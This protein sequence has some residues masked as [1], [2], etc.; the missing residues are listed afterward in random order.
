MTRG[1]F[2]LVCRGCSPGDEERFYEPGV[3]AVPIGI[4][5]VDQPDGLEL[6]VYYGNLVKETEIEAWLNSTRPVESW[7]IREVPN[8]DWIL[9]VQKLWKPIPIGSFFIIPPGHPQPDRPGVIVIEPRQAFGTGLHE[10]T[11]GMLRLMERANLQGQ[12]VLDIGTGT[13]I[14]AIAAVKLGAESVI[15]LDIDEQAIL[16]A[17]GNINHNTLP[18]PIHLVQGSFDCLRPGIADV[19]LT[20][21]DAKTL[22]N[23]I[24]SFTSL[25][26][27][28]GRWIAGGI[29]NEEASLF[30]HRAASLSME[31]LDQW[32]KGPW[33][34]YTLGIHRVANS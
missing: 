27:P 25:L 20:N 13:G 2:E 19:V 15:A 10:S 21:I 16:E 32:D 22:A 26:S 33:K 7:Q 24:S 4:H 28:E 23:S 30:L 5:L 31:I 11:H 1:L 8:Q 34:G 6:H 14:L 17:S 12:R 3:P 9:D 29:Y 18:V